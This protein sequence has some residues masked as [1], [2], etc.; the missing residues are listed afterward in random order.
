MPEL[1]EVETIRRGLLPK[2]K[3]KK[4][5]FAILTLPRLLQYPDSKQFVHRLKNA[6]VMD[7][8]RHGKYLLFHLDNQLD[9]MIHLGMTGRLFIHS[10]NQPLDKH[11]HF[12]LKLHTSEELRFVDARTFGKLALVSHND[13]SPVVGL[14]H[15]GIDPLS[16]KFTLQKFA[17]VFE[18]N[19]QLK[20]VLMDQ[21]RIAG[22]GNI[23]VD[24]VLHRARLNPKKSVARLKISQIESLFNAICEILKKALLYRGTTILSYVDTEV[25][26]GEYQDHL[27]VY[28]R[29]NE[30]CRNCNKPI[31]RIVL[32]SR[33]T[34]YCPK[35]QK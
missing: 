30:P 34:F 1:P 16:P 3:G 27:K 18:C 11:T 13:Y 26:Y 14:A 6:T 24:E 19:R 35:C 31:R 5:D 7:I 32:V 20:A 25:R 2:I 29:E 12:R 4:I 23:Y 33:S 10:S 21:S 9:L 15:L 8:G 17:K 22:L 28:G